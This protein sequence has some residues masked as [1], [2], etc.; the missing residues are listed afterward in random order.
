MRRCPSLDT[1]LRPLLVAVRR[2][3]NPAAPLPSIN[4]SARKYFQKRFVIGSH[5]HIVTWILSSRSTRAGG[6][7]R[8]RKDTLTYQLAVANTNLALDFKETCEARK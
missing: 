8:P 6:S 1:R 4:R 7:L 5:F 3:R 2:L